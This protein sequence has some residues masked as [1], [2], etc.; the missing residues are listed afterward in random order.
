[1]SAITPAAPR[2]VLA[3]R[4]FGRSL[5][6]DVV[7]VVAGAALTAVLAQVA[8]PPEVVTVQ[9]PAVTPAGTVPPL[10]TNVILGWRPMMP[11][12]RLSARRTVAVWVTATSAPVELVTVTVERVVSTSRI[13]AVAVSEPSSWHAL[14]ESRIPRAAAEPCRKAG[15]FAFRLLIHK[16]VIPIGYIDQTQ[17]AFKKWARRRILAETVPGSGAGRAG[18][19]AAKPR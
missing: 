6:L 2:L 4:V 10:F 9:V 8:V 18:G 16:L 5:V 7:L 14:K 15:I 3:D 1:M 17:D 12:P 19:R 11:A 13:G